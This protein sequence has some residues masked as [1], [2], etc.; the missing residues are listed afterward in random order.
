MDP[1]TLAVL[2]LVGL[3]ILVTLIKFV[4][5]AFKTLLGAVLFGGLGFVLYD[6]QGLA[7][8]ALLG[9]VLGLASALK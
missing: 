4:K 1:I 8:G 9:C 5:A 6:S 3:L 7:F 2:V